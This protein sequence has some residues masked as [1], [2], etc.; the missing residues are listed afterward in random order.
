MAAPAVRHPIFARVFHRVSP[1]MEKEVGRH[2][3][4]L[5]AGLTGRVVEVGAGNGMSFAHYPPSVTEV[6]ALEPESYLRAKAEEAARDARVPVSVRDGVADPLPF[7]AGEF[8]AAVASLVLCSVPDQLRALAELRRVVRPGG[9]LRFFEHVR[10]ESPRKARVQAGLDRSGLWP[11]MGGGCHCARDT[12][13]SIEAA[14]F[15]VER[16]R[17]LAVGP[18][19]SHTNPHVLGLART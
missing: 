9:E 6:V 12:V 4:E 18:A 5:L 8:D 14:G 10:A 17:T 1:S 2:R 3:D 13:A 7:E 15:A 11:L 19:W 16:I